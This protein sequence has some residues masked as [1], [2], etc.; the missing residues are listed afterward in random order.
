[1]F[2]KFG[3]S[4][5]ERKNRSEKANKRQRFQLSNREFNKHHFQM[6]LDRCKTPS[7]PDKKAK[8]F[9]VSHFPPLWTGE[10]RVKPDLTEI[11]RNF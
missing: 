10:R 11:V 9:H 8:D 4:G 7:G 6:V 3:G 5:T 1:M 2:V